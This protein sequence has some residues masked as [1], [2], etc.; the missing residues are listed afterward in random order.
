M[1]VQTCPFCLSG[2]EYLE[3]MERHRPW[4]A[5]PK[6][7]VECNNCDARGPTSDDAATALEKWNEVDR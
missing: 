2:N 4:S 3:M 6:F 7:Y 1:I 5:R